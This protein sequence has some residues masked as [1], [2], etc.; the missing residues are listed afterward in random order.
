MDAQTPSVLSG[1]YG[2]ERAGDVSFMW[3]SGQAVV[4][5]AGI[6]RQRPW[7]CVASVRGGRAPGVSQPTVVLA[8]DGVSGATATAT[9]SYADIE[10]Q[11]PSRPGS[12]GLVLTIASSSTF[13]PGPGDT[14]ELGVQ[15]DGVTCRPVGAAGLPPRKALVAAAIAAAFFALTFTVLGAPL[16]LAAGG[17]IAIGIAEAVALTA[18]PALYTPYVDRIPF[19]AGA[20]AIGAALIGGLMAWWLD[21]PTSPAARFVLAYSASVL[22]ILLLGLLHPS[23]PVS[24]A[25]FHAH[26]LEWV[27]GGRY[28]FTQPMPGG[29]AFPYAIALYVVSLPFT[30][31]TSDHVTLLRIVVCTAHVGAGA[32]LYTAIVRRWQDPLAGAIAVV[33]WALIPRWYLVVGYA[34]LTNAFGQS[35]ATMTMVSAVVLALGSRDVLQAGVL[36][37]LASVALLSHVSTFPLLTVALV[38]LAVCYW[39]LGDATLQSPARVI[40]AVTVA[41]ALFAVLAYY[42]RFAEVYKSLDRVA[43]R[44]VAAVATAPAAPEAVKG[45]ASPP[46]RGGPTPAVPVRAATAI[47]EGVRAIGWPIVLLAVLGAW[48]VVAG[49]WRDRLSL[50]LLAWVATCAVFLLFAVVAPV[51][52]QFYRYMIEFIGRVYLATWPAFVI[53]A[54]LGVSWAWRARGVSR[55]AAALLVAWACGIGAQQW[56]GWFR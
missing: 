41:A 56:L 9:N 32:L 3:T 34:N 38:L 19:L 55:V 29:V 14:R 26:R 49:R 46:P 21:R 13:V 27:Q 12:D 44:S 20:A 31:L 48:R 17:A 23:K 5:L 43:G 53:L 15:L 6:D 11:A 1:T 45:A 28:F 7:R 42:G 10:V 2:P 8:V 25:L 22:Y 4:T 33:L 18:G 16:W 30:A 40:A 36:F 50:A 24:D 52:D 39:W 51:E 37:V 47:A 54:G 35:I